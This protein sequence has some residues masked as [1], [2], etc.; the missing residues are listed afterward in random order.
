VNYSVGQIQTNVSQDQ[1]GILKGATL[2]DGLLQGYAAQIKGNSKDAL[3]CGAPR[4]HVAELETWT[5]DKARNGHAESA[6]RFQARVL[7]SLAPAGTDAVNVAVGIESKI[8]DYFDEIEPGVFRFRLAD[9][10]AGEVQALR[11]LP[12]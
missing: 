12:R 3:E 4:K 9:F 1:P 2:F 6:I 8:T 7:K 11:W 10:L 5:V